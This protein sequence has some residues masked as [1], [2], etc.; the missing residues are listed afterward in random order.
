MNTSIK[1]R[2]KN[3]SQIKDEIIEEKIFR[4]NML[5]L[6]IKDWYKYSKCE[7]KYFFIKEDTKFKNIY[8]ICNSYGGFI[9]WV[10]KEWIEPV[11]LQMEFNY[12]EV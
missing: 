8:K 7:E 2:Y 10:H 12:D 3:S 9:T 1:Y 11:N 5:I 4:N 6:R